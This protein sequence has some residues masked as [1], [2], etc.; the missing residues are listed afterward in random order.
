M[1]PFTDVETKERLAIEKRR[2]AEEERRKRILDPKARTMGL[3][4]AGIQSQIEEKEQIKKREQDRDRY[5]DQASL[6]HAKVANIMEKEMHQTKKQVYKEVN[7]FRKNEQLPHTRREF[8]LNDPDELKKSRPIRVGDYDPSLTISGGQIMHGEDLG[9]EE[10][11]KAQQDQLKCWVSE[12]VNEKQ[13][14]KEKE[15][16][17]RKLFEQKE[18]EI[19]RLTY[20]LREKENM[21]KL[22]KERERKEFN[23]EQWNDKEEKE[24]LQREKEELD[25][26]EEIQNQLNS[27]LLNEAFHTTLN[28]N[29]PNRFRPDH[30]KHMRPDQY[31][32][33]EQ[34]RQEQLREL[35]QKR[36]TES[37]NQ[38]YWDKK[39]LLETKMAGL[40]LREQERAKKQQAAELLELHKR[41]AEEKKQKEK[42][43]NQ[44]YANE[45]TEDFFNRFGTSSR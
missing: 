10:R 18:L 8:D 43:V 38:Q 9:R 26:L 3:D 13:M 19:Q 35:Q 24:K 1:F 31:E 17:E 20:E 45:V 4:V 39:R 42:F 32:H 33:I 41:Q 30:F 34:V 37:L 14:V 22:E 40:Q 29:D 12:Q 36:D 28:V 44:V 15:D 27:H 2:Q 25:K 11:L 6:V 16:L 7:D 21:I 5:F 23:V